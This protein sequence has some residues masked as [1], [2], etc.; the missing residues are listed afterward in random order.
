MA[1]LNWNDLFSCFMWWH[2]K[3]CRESSTLS[4]GWS[5]GAALIW[6]PSFQGGMMG[7]IT[8]EWWDVENRGC[9]VKEGRKMR[10]ILGGGVKWG[11]EAILELHSVVFGSLCTLSVPPYCRQKGTHTHTD[12]SVPDSGRICT[13][14]WTW[15]IICSA[16]NQTSTVRT[17][18]ASWLPVVFQWGSVASWGMKCVEWINFHSAETSCCCSA[19]S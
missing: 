3:P 7:F 4:V 1:L 15:G 18:E 14:D 12:N 13:R 17:S 19:G 2:N 16:Q 10:C 8:F 6:P 9:R 5:N 11:Q